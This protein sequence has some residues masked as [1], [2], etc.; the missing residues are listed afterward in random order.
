MEDILSEAEGL[1]K[2]GVK[3]LILIAQDT[4]YYGV[5]IYGKSR[6]SDLINKLCELD[7]RWIRLQYCYPERIT[8]ELIETIANQEKVCKYLDLPIQHCEDSILSRMD[9]V[10]TKQSLIK[11]IDKIRKKIPDIV[12]RTTLIVGFPGET[13][14]DF[15]SLCDFVKQSRFD[16]LGVFT[17][18]QEEGTAASLM[19]DQIDEQVKKQ[20]KE[21]I[22]YIQTEV[23]DSISKIK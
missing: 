2:R 7:L 6:L 19:E 17:Y 4:T 8:D 22:E 15:N 20:R 16:R 23:A 1:V 13:E 5:D 14:Q 11:L 9:R 12:L 10:G 18:S 3:E 21:I